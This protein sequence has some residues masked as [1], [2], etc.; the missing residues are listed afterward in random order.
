V[1]RLVIL[2]LT[3]VSHGNANGVGI[4][5]FTT[6]R[7]FR[8]LSFTDTYPNSL[9]S[10]VPTSVKIPMVLASDRLAIQAGVRTCNVA[11]KTQARVIRIRDTLEVGTIHVS[12]SL[13]PEVRAHDSM[14]A[15][16]DPEPLAFDAAG[17]LF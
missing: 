3:D 9:T 7:L 4:G 12:E 10:T 16:G 11:D 17:N 6:E 15:T 8:K 1:K 14:R 13:L 5:D 2:D